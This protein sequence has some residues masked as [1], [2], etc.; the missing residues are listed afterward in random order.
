MKIG[1][2]GLGTMGK[3]MAQNLL[4]SFPDNCFYF[5]AR[6]NDVIAEFSNMGAIYTCSLKQ[7]GQLCDVIFII[8]GTGEQCKECITGKE[9]LL[10]S[11]NK[12]ILIIT[13]TIGRYDLAYIETKCKQRSINVLDAP[14]S[15]GVKKAYDGSLTFMVSGSI[16]VFEKVKF[17]FKAIAENVYFI[18]E[19][20]GSAQEIKL[21]NQMLVGIHMSA[22][23]EI[24]SLGEKMGLD[25][26]IIY[27]VLSHSAGSSY[28]FENRGPT[29][30]QRDF[31]TRSTLAI[32]KKDLTLACDLLEE[33][34]QK[35]GLTNICKNFFEQAVSKINPQEDA[36]AIIKLFE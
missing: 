18:N 17:L 32:M 10:S 34:G 7:L 16:Q 29:I 5:Y 14:I 26:N 35:K 30:I 15:G 3:P 25:P 36:S 27:L 4:C 12:G 22:T 28:I 23:A 11:M 9:G 13:S 1:F 31:S 33:Y 19:E 6:K 20:I 21:L 8:L 24:F 2:L